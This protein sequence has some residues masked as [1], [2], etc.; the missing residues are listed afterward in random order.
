MFADS[1]YY[2]AASDCEESPELKSDYPQFRFEYEKVEAMERES[3]DCIRVD[4]E[5]GFSC[6]F[7]PDHEIA[8]D[9]EQV[10]PGDPG[11]GEM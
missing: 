8:V 10:L 2:E 3:D 9:P 5:S 11:Y 7:P 6:G 1:A 4:F